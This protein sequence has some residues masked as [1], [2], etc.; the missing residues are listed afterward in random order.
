MID[1]EMTQ[2]KKTPQTNKQTTAAQMPL[3]SSF[4]LLQFFKHFRDN[5][6]LKIW[7]ESKASRI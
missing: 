7:E 3:W 4:S 6:H 1:L 2:L 5:F